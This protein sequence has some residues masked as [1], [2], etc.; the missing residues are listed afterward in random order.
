MTFSFTSLEFLTKPLRGA[1]GSVSK[2][3]SLATYACVL[4][5][6]LKAFRDRLSNAFL[7]VSESG[8]REQ[9]IQE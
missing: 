6:L 7:D 5:V 1:S 4:R 2:D 8:P 3:A 9:Y